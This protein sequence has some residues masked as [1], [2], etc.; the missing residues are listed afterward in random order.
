MVSS[1]GGKAGF[2]YKSRH[3]VYLKLRAK[4]FSKEAAAKISNAGKTHGQ[5]VAMSRKAAK[6]RKRRGK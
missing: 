3:K 4:G 5:R 6:T 2:V 1:K